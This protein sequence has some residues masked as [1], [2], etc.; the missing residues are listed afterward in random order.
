MNRQTIAAG[1]RNLGLAQKPVAVHSSLRSFG[2]VAGGPQTVIEALQEICST[3]LMPGFQC[4]A[5]ILPPLEERRHQNGCDYGVH[6]DF[7]NPPQPFDVATAPI[8][9]KMGVICHTLANMPDVYRSNHPWHSWLATGEK[10]AAWTA[11]HPWDTTNRPLESLESAGGFVLLLGVSLS[12][13]TAIHV[14]EERAGRKAFVRWA[15]NGERKLCEVLTSGCAKGFDALLPHCRHLFR[16]ER[17]G[18]CIAQAAPIGELM[19]TLAQVMREQPELTRC[20]KECLRCN[21]AILGGP[22][23]RGL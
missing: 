19:K 20:S 18:N 17:I 8:H 23:P 6:F 9:P 16:V 10:A 21:D 11:D 1:L 12:S 13:C 15:M 4:A 5:K 2:Q 14:A 3:I 22:L 7:V